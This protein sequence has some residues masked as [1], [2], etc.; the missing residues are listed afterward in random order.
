MGASK[1]KNNKDLQD[2]DICSLG[3]VPQQ[4]FS[5]IHCSIGSPQFAKNPLHHGNPP[6]YFVK[7]FPLV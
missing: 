3:F 1:K 2:F 7:F 5:K 6:I 4:P